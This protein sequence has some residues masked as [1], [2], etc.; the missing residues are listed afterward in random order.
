MTPAASF[1]Q[2]AHFVSF[3]NTQ[4]FPIRGIVEVDDG[5]KQDATWLPTKDQQG[6]MATGPRETD[7]KKK[8]PE[9]FWRQLSSLTIHHQPFSI[10]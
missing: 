7:E 6:R 8:I 4:I 10:A 2:F 5:T 1:Q 3:W 9:N